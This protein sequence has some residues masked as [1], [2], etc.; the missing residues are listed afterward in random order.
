[1]AGG[2]ARAAGQLLCYPADALRTI[3]QTRTGARTVAELGPRVLVSG[4][5]TTSALALPVG[6]VQF[7]AFGVIKRRLDAVFGTSDDGSGAAGRSGGSAAAAVRVASSALAAV[8]S[9]SISVPQEV[10]KSRLVTGIHP[11]FAEAVRS[12]AKSEGIRG[13][14]VG[15]LPTAA[16]N[17][18]FVVITF[19]LYG[20]LRHHA[21]SRQGGG[22]LSTAQVH[23][24]RCRLG[25]FY[26][27]IV[28]FLPRS[29]VL[30]CILFEFGVFAYLP[31][32]SLSTW[33]AAS[34]RLWR[35]A[36]RRSPW[37]LLRPG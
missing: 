15:A 17:I 8:A 25:N 30:C 36:S 19:T 21:L 26:R 5:L 7:S 27:S 12:I 35:P 28:I 3:A 20:H 2:F 22:E 9:C 23:S 18:P 34:P 29:D 32:G 37:T 24:T 33:G 6:A 10:V 31:R 11:S 14:Y 4:A 1:M 16:R 13:F